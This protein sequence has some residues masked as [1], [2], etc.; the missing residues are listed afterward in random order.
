MSKPKYDIDSFEMSLELILNGLGIAI[1]NQPYI[2]A[3][4]DK[5]DLVEL[6]SSIKFPTRTLYVAINK[7][8]L[9]NLL[10]LDFSFSYIVHFLIYFSLK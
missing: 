3:Y 5:G 1:F 2:Q 9:Q 6:E 8:N 4:L 10:Y 7:K